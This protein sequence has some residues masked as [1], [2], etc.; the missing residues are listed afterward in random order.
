MLDPRVYRAAFIPVLLALFVVAFSLEARPRALGTT[1]AADAFDG[2]AAFATL[3]DYTERFA[4]RR[5]GGRGDTELAGRV[6]RDLAVLGPGTVKRYRAQAQTIDG[7]RT[8]TTV[9]ATRPG[10]PGPGLVLVAHRDAAGA[11]A[12]A[13]L[14]GTAALVELARVAATGRL[15]RTVT[16]VSTSGGSGGMAGARAAIGRLPPPVDAVLVLGDLASRTM[17]KPWVVGWSNGP[18]SAPQ[19][20][21]R[22]LEAA[23]RAEVGEDPGAPRAAAQWARYAFPATPAEPGAYGQAGLASVGLSVTGELPPAAGAAV[24][25]GRLT[26][27]GRAAL[28]TVYALDNGPD[29]ATGPEGGLIIQRKLLPGWAVI[30]LVGAGLLPFWVAVLDGLLRVH[31]RGARLA[32]GGLWVLASVLPFALTAV[33]AVALGGVGLIGARPGAPVPAG[34]MPVDAKA[35]GVV[36]VLGLVLVLGWIGLRPLLLH[37]LGSAKSYGDE[38][39]AAALGTLAAVLFALWLAN[40]FAAGLLVLPAHA[41]LLAAATDVRLRR[42]AAAGLAL[43][44]LL[45][46][47][48]ALLSLKAQ[49]G[50]RPGEAVW[51]LVLGIAGGHVAPLGWLMGSVL[52]GVAVCVG[53]LVATRPR[54]HPLPGEARNPMAVPGPRSYAEPGSLGGTDS[55]LRR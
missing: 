7:E 50:L 41:W 9:V 49:L 10:R 45:P 40:P 31:R 24:D 20:L 26:A 55:A 52:L 2:D 35:A 32:A 30:L 33:F 18:G 34:A 25:K 6:A 37:P 29:I 1:V 15:R 43:T 22:T 53:L 17:R 16:F 4:E 36:A 23:I 51:S 14:S 3:R 42:W 39:S 48:L 46:L 19:Q 47:T 5:P 12:A 28:R 54:E 11:P 21:R 27:F 13:E 44:A 38:H 8:V